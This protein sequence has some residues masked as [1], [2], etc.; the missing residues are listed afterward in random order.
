MGL[1][2]FRA[3]YMDFEMFFERKFQSKP[4]K[5]GMN[6]DKIDIEKLTL[7][8][9]LWHSQHSNGRTFECR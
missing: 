1:T 2:C 3:K 8:Y 4:L 9:V 6:K 5:N 7:T